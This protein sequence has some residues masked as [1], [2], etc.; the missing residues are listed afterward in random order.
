[1]VHKP[2]YHVQSRVASSYVTTVAVFSVSC[3][4]ISIYRHMLLLL[5]Y[6]FAT[7]CR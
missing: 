2:A 3:T 5:L 6:V 4:M 1:M 7:A